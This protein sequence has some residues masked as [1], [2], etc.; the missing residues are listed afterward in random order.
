MEDLLNLDL[1][2]YTNNFIAEYIW[3]YRLC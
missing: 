1:T 2:P 3:Y